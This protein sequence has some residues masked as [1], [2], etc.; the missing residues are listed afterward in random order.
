MMPSCQSQGSSHNRQNCQKPN[1]QSPKCHSQHF[2]TFTPHQHHSPGGA[3]NSVW[4]NKKEEREFDLKLKFIKIR[5]KMKRYF[6]LG[7]L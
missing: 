4:S 6:L 7:D 1:V 3:E 2:K 5:R